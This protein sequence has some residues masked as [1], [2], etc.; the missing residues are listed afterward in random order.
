[1]LRDTAERMRRVGLLNVP[2]MQS[3]MDYLAEIKNESGLAYE[4]PYFGP[5]DRG[6]QAKA[7][8]LLEVPG[9]KA[10]SS[11][12]ISSNNPDPTAKNLWHL[13]RKANIP[14]ADVLLWSIVP[15]YV[16]GAGR[17]RPVNSSDIGEALPY[18]KRLI[19][20]LPHLELIVLV[21]KK[22][23]SAHDQIQ[24]M[25]DIHIMQTCHM[26]Q[27]VFSVWPHKKRETQEDFYAV[28]CFLRKE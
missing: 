11:T 21:G 15:W 2:H 6:I 16:G 10:V 1:L 23:Q 13:L 14:R 8:F 22:A 7:L 5:C 25:T 17:I 26:S 28:A 3:L 12:F 27:R 20:L 19:G 4:M 18:L 9:P 24:S